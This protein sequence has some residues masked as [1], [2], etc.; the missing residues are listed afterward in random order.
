MIF[1]SFQCQNQKVALDVHE[2]DPSG[3]YDALLKLFDHLILFD[4]DLSVELP[5]V[6]E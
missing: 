4:D 1:L 5:P 6:F 2:I 3:E